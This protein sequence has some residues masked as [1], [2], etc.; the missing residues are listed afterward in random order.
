M[1]SGRSS[2]VRSIAPPSSHAGAHMYSTDQQ[3]LFGVLALQMDFISPTQFAEACTVWASRKD[4]SLLELLTDR[5]WLQSQDVHDIERLLAR[6]V[7]RNGGDIAASLREVANDPRVQGSL[8]SVADSEIHDTLRPS[9]SH[10]F[11]SLIATQAHG[12]DSLGRYT[13]SHV[14]ATGGIGR[15]WLAHDPS[16]RREVALKELRPDRVASATI[17]SRFLR[18]AQVTGQLEHPGIVPIYEVGRRPDDDAPYYTMRFVRGRTLA[19]AV[20]AYHQRRVKGE[21]GPLEL[22]EIL[23][24]FVGVCNAI[25]YAH[26]R[27][28]LHRDLKPQNIILGS[29]GEVMVLDWG[30]ARVMDEPEPGPPPVDLESIDA[31]DATRAGKVLGTPAYMPPE[32]AAGRIDLFGPK[33]DVFGLGAVLYHILANRPPFVAATQDEVVRLAIDGVIRPVSEIVAETPPP[34]DAICLKALSKAPEDRYSSATALA[35]EVQRWLADAS[36]Q[37]YRDP[38]AARIGRWMRNHQTFVTAATVFLVCG[39]AALTGVTGLIWRQKQE[40]GR[41]LART[42]DFAHGLVDA[43]DKAQGTA[44]DART[45]IARTGVQQVRMLR[46][47]QPENGSLARTMARLL[48]FEATPKRLTRR[49]AEA[50]A[51]LLEAVSTLE[52]FVRSESND[53]SYRMMSAATLLNLGMVQT[54]MGKRRDAAANLERAIALYGDPPRQELVTRRNR[55]IATNELSLAYFGWKPL[56]EV[57]R[58][59]REAATLL[60]EV[61]EDLKPEDGRVVRLLQSSALNRVAQCRCELK[62]PS[63]GLKFLDQSAAVLDELLAARPNDREALHFRAHVWLAKATTCTL[64]A[65]GT[66]DAVEAFNN[67]V[68]IWQ[69][70]V[71][72]APEASTFRLMLSQSLTRRADFHRRQRL[73]PQAEADLV[74]ADKALEPLSPP[75][76][77]SVDYYASQAH[78]AEIR[79]RLALDIKDYASSRKHLSAAREAYGHWI[80]ADADNESAR[81]SLTSLVSDV[82]GTGAK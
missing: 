24:A 15:V 74:E 34:L 1:S 69:R 63:D 56:E 65:T 4:T 33:T 55:A 13:L 79:T 43:A 45:M 30:L 7:E 27:G 37:A 2:V 40:T 41:H 44:E 29:F 16:L 72:E 19:E 31:A 3:L 53:P 54:Q 38:L 20:D 64:I 5:G 52:P 61:V 51:A 9:A 6:R 32:Q 75:A 60:A 80:Q 76:K 70:L 22:R 28:V 68:S 25:G 66:A 17:Q 39:I 71:R 21:E 12:S 50:E 82:E 78:T 46:Q 62:Q 59:S 58:S 73:R 35:E 67:A 10:R 57:E 49:Y 42:A 23:A 47:E 11:M 18:E 8:A 26:S 48:Q 81:S 14:H 36:V 77:T